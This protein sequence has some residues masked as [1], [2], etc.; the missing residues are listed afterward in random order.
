MGSRCN[1]RK[2]FRR[3]QG[4][5]LTSITIHVPQAGTYTFSLSF[6]QDDSGPAIA[7]PN[8]TETFALWQIGHEWGGP[9]CLTPTMQAELPPPPPTGQPPLQVICPGP[10]PAHP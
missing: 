4:R 3:D 5:P 1:R 2:S 6:W 8:I 9:Q 7:A 10:P